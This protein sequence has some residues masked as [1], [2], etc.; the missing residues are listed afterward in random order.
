M[1]QIHNFH[2]KLLKRKDIIVRVTGVSNP[3]YAHMQKSL[4]EHFKADE[5]LIVIRKINSG[6]GKNQFDV[7]F[8][9]Y[10]SEKDKKATEPVVKVKEAK[11]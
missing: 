1:E 10:D 7:E 11:K 4:S 9:I 2:N 6:F 5:N 3:G 8:S